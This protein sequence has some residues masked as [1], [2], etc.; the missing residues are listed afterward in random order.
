MGYAHIYTQHLSTKLNVWPQIIT[1]M[2]GSEEYILPN[3]WQVSTHF[4][5][6]SCALHNVNLQWLQHKHKLCCFREVY[7][8]GT[9]IPEFLEIM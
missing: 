4:V 7:G 1:S 2:M 3:L 6:G 5:C 8:A 9:K